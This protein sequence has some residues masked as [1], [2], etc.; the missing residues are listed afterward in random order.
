MIRAVGLLSDAPS[1]G[2]V[3]DPLRVSGFVLVRCA[4]QPIRMSVAA[5]GYIRG[6]DPGRGSLPGVDSRSKGDPMAVERSSSARWQGNL[7]DGNGQVTVGRGAYTGSYTFASR[8]ESGDGTNPEELIAAAHAACYSM[9][10]SNGLAGDGHTP[11]SIST[12]AT[13]TLDGAQITK[14]HLVCHGQVPGIDDET[15]EKYAQDAKS[16]CPVSKLLTGADE[17]TLDATLER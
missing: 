12:E 8:W 14:I 3:L 13:V 6:G 10:L 15:F 9:A 4:T 17:I 16:N 11:D 7:K 1:L 2:N 5:C